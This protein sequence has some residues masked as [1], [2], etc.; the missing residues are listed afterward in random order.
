[1]LLFRNQIACCLGLGCRI[2]PLDVD[3]ALVQDLQLVA[4]LH[5]RALTLDEARGRA[6]EAL[7]LINKGQKSLNISLIRLLLWNNNDKDLLSP[8]VKHHWLSRDP[9]LPRLTCKAVTLHAIY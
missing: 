9:R 7:E 1:M 5:E 8:P 4:V 2:A 3:S 6:D